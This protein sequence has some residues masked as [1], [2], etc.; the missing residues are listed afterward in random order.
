MAR[1]V[2]ACVSGAA[3]E[4]DSH[5]I[6][7]GA[8]ENREWPASGKRCA[9]APG[10][11]ER[12]FV[13]RLRRCQGIG[14]AAE[15]RGGPRP[16]LAKVAFHGTPVRAPR[17]LG[18]VIGPELPLAGFEFSRVGC[19][20]ALNARARAACAITVY[21]AGRRCSGACRCRLGDRSALTG[22]KNVCGCHDAVRVFERREEFEPR[23]ARSDVSLRKQNGFRCCS[24][25]EIR[26]PARI[27]RR[28][29]VPRAGRGTR[30]GDRASPR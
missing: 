23:F 21:L 8:G 18:E 4:P 5:H 24:P 7:V 20:Q 14:V 10:C 30:A 6:E 17:R 29:F 16:K 2:T 15:D 11:R 12:R 3:E 13:G 1:T 25:G 27:P 19:E 26:P 28:R 9:I 22:P